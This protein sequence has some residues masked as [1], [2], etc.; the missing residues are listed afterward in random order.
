M[1]ESQISLPIGEIDNRIASL[2]TKAAGLL[3]EATKQAEKLEYEAAKLEALKALALEIGKPINRAA[4]ARIVAFGKPGEWTADMA[5][6]IL[7]KTQPLRIEQIIHLLK[8]AGWRGSGDDKKD[9]KN[10]HTNLS[11]KPKRFRS[12]SRGLFALAEWNGKEAESIRKD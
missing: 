4:S 6:E 2:R 5:E 10:V 1:N 7:K 9:Y 11:T 3:E 12:V 8:K